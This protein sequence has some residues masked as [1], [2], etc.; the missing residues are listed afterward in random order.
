MAKIVDNVK[1][2]GGFSLMTLDGVTMGRPGQFVMVRPGK[3]LDPLLGRPI[4]LYNADEEHTYLL[5]QKVG[6]GTEMLQEL[7]EGDEIEVTGPFGNGFPLEDA[8]IVLIGGGVGVAPLYYLAKAHRAAYPDRKITVHLGFREKAM[9]TEEY[10]AVCDELILNIGGF[11]TDDVDYTMDATYY[12]C[13]PTPM[14]NAAA[15]KAREANAKLY[16]SLENRMACGAG[17]CLC[18]TCKTKSGNKR[19]CKDGPVFPAEEVFYE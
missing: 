8:D 7:R 17:A 5:Y 18:C 6:R 14:M 2:E 15:V 11:V 4:S 3:G 19:A 1:L 12:A 16:V 10:S 13:G 9:L